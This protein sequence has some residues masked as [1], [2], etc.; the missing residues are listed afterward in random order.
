M[1][2]LFG[3]NDAKEV[4]RNELQFHAARWF[5]A[6]L[7]LAT[8]KVLKARHDPGY[9]V[10]YVVV[11]D[12][13]GQHW[14]FT[15]LLVQKQGFWFVKTLA[16]GPEEVLNESPELHDCPWIRLQ[17]LYVA[18]EFH[19][20]G[21]VLDKGYQIVRVRL[22]DQSGLVLE[23]T[24]QDGIVLFLS[25]QLPTVPPLQLELYNDAGRLVSRQT[26]KPQFPP[27]VTKE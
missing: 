17:E 1:K 7:D 3:S 22:L 24:V 16:G 18:N 21:E 20:F 23:D 26:Q 2:P 4:I 19:A 25:E 13:T 6:Q 15:L 8:I 9:Q 5:F 11:H 27:F 12:T 10:Q 14:H